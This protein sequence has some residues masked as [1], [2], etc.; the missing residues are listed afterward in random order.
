MGRSNE[1]EVTDQLS[2]PVGGEE[3][4]LHQGIFT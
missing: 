2:D 1:R 4:G 3:L